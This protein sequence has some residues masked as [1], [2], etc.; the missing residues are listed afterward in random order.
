MF[1]FAF[2]FG[3]DFMSC[4]IMNWAEGNS[5]SWKLAFWWLPM[6]DLQLSWCLITVLSI[7]LAAQSVHCVDWQVEVGKFTKLLVGKTQQ[8]E[9]ERNT[10]RGREIMRWTCL[11][12]GIKIA[13]S[14]MALWTDSFVHFVCSASYSSSNLRTI[15]LLL[16]KH[17]TCLLDITSFGDV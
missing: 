6:A 11:A 13:S 1:C 5:I 16:Y 15:V 3:D 2:N 10:R 8:K 7:S 9:V 4:N 14:I 17:F 12:P